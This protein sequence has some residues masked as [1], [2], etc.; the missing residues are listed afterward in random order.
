M[1]EEVAA[2]AKSVEGAEVDV[3][4]LRETLPAEVIEKMGAVEA[5][6]AFAH[7]PEADSDRLSDADAILFG[8]PTRFG[9]MAATHPGSHVGKKRGLKDEEEWRERRRGNPQAARRYTFL[10][11]FLAES[12]LTICVIA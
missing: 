6:K 12:N 3:S 9:N 11:A 10:A 1:A 8:A 5:R 2:G 7:V 4:Q